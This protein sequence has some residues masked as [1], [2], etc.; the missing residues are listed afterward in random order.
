MKAASIMTMILGIAFQKG[1]HNI[2]S[3]MKSIHLASDRDSLLE[4]KKCD[5]R[6]INTANGQSLPTKGHSKGL[7]KKQHENE[8]QI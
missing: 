8:K 1:S 4:F 2:S 6:K 7:Y 3:S 5:I